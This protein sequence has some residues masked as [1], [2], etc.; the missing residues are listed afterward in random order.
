LLK[1]QAAALWYDDEVDINTIPAD[2][3]GNVNYIKSKMAYRMGDGS[4]ETAS[5]S[6]HPDERVDK[7]LRLA[8]ETE[9]TQA[10]DRLRS[11]R[12]SLDVIKR[13]GYCVI[14]HWM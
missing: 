11:V 13:Y 12:S 2:D 14:F 5:V 9:T 4:I 6:T 3:S 7:L 1:N 8:R 10:I